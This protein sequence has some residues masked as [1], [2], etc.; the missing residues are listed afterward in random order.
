VVRANYRGSGN[1][2]K[3]FKTLHY[4]KLGTLEIDDYAAVIRQI[5]ERPYADGSRVGVY[6]HSYGGYA[7][8]LLLLRYPDLFHVGVSGAPVTDWRSY[9]T[10]YT[11]RYMNTPQANKE[12]YDVGSAMN[13]ADQLEGKLLLVH[14]TIDNNVHPG[15]TIQLVDAL[16]K[17][18]KKFDLMMYPD[19]RHGIRGAHGRHYNK[20]RLNYL[21][22]HLNPEAVNAEDEV[23]G[24]NWSNVQVTP[25]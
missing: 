1:R 7:T 19:N 13:Y 11:E 4:G 16:V 18:D 2:G 24:I 3:A 10:I 21:I 12:G 15:N 20:M 25:E 22:E 5:T 17:A 23:I 8:S 6:G 14:G 9:D